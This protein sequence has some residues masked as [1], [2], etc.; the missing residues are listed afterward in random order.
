MSSFPKSV[1]KANI[2]PGISYNCQA[3]YFRD[4]LLGPKDLII[5]CIPL[6]ELKDVYPILHG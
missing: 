4:I 6:K 5:H 3:T 1:F 2:I